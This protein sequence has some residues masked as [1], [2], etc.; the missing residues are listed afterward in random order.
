LPH[1]V[2]LTYDSAH[3]DA[4]VLKPVFNGFKGATA[5][6]DEASEDVLIAPVTRCSA[7]RP[8]HWKDINERTPRRSVPASTQAAIA[9]GRDRQ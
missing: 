1:T 7:A 9:F 2:D 5:D 4:S 3:R 8:V 6:I